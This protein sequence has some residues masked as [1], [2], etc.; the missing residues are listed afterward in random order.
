MSVCYITK[1]AS[2]LKVMDT[3]LIIHENHK[4]AFY[5]YKQLYIMGLFTAQR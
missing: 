3:L 4:P 1:N 5:T 2:L